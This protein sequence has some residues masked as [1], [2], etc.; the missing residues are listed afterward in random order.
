M[1]EALLQ[2]PLQSASVRFRWTKIE[3][4]G[5]QRKEHIAVFGRSIIQ[6]VATCVYDN[7]HRECI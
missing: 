1:L 7:L 3:K 6:T 4:Y 5:V 2:N